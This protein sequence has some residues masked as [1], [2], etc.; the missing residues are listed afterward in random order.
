MKFLKNKNLE[1]INN[2]KG[3]RHFNNQ[4]YNDVGRKQPNLIDLLKWKFTG[5]SRFINKKR[6]KFRLQ[7]I[8][9]SFLNNK[10]NMIVWLGHAS[11]YIQIDG[12]K[13]ITDPV[14]YS[15]PF[16]KRFVD[17]PFNIDEMKN[18]DYILISHGH[19][20][21]FDHKSIKKILENSTPKILAPL[22]FKKLLHYYQNVEE[23]GWF[24]KFNIDKLEISL[25]PALHW[26]SRYILD[27]NKTL[28]GSFIIKH[29][30]VNI[31]FAGDSAYGEHYKDIGK[32]YD[33]DYALM[34]IG[35][36]K[37]DFIMKHSHMSPFESIVAANDLNAKQ[38][39]PM[40]YGTYDLSDETI[41]E[42]LNDLNIAKSSFNG[43]IKILKIGELL[44]V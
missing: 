41:S 27:Y 33:V 18:I 17:I 24:Q 12:L 44:K 39:I 40:H 26:H 35:A 4:F 38:F 37:P 10:E 2:Y 32:L 43:N 9:S 31:Y 16:F 20:D 1:S 36:Y 14:L 5:F 25:L 19:R 7:P 21:H 15:L 13:I 28:W 23:A 11:F 34:P 22:G 30:K 6:D 29:N 8:F 3:N 42:P